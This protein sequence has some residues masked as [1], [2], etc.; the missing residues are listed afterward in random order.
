MKELKKIVVL[1]PVYPYK[2]GIA[3]YTSLLAKSLAAK[4]EVEMVSYSMQYPKIMMRREQRDYSNKSFAVENTK[5]LINTAN[6][7][8]WGKV[9]KQI[10]EMQPDLIVAQWWHPYFA[11]CYQSI[12]GR[13]SK[14]IPVIYICHN[15]FPHERFPMDR[16]LSK[17]TL[18][19]AA[20]IVQSAEDEKD[21]LS[22]LPEHK[23]RRAMHPTYSAFCMR[24]LNRSEARKELGIGE[25]EKMLL[26]F[27]FV[28]PYKGLMFLLEAMPRLVQT[29]PEMKLYVVG[30][31]GSAK[32]EYLQKME[33]LKIMDH[34]VIRDG[35]VPDGEV[36]PYFA[37]ADLCVCPYASAT[38][39][40]IVQISFGSG[41]PVLATRVGGLPEAVSDGE[42]GL[43]VEPESPVA[44]AEGI[45][46]FFEENLAENFRENIK[47]HQEEF[48]WDR[49]TQK[50]EDLYQEMEIKK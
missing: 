29:Y 14:T 28:R 22:I 16:K 7:F 34:L 43:I 49:M 10:K 39:S 20:C 3:H 9:V 42:T 30:D 24:G 12:L 1:G 45:T 41:L 44:L 36:E 26:F 25:N 19:K 35:Y 40:G 5:Y 37:A 18:K 23:Y 32:E 33:S 27:G 6:P 11:P 47:V 50:I 46:K 8:N 15:V 4:Y 21:L 48:S 17:G 38:Q 2:G 31:F 13:L